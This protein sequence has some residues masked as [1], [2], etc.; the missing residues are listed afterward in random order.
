MPRTLNATL[1]AALDSG[2]FQAYF[3]LTVREVGAV[4][5]Y[6][7]ATPLKFELHGINLS[8]TYKR[9]QGSVYDGFLYP[10]EMEFMVTRGVTIAGVN[11]TINSSYYFGVTQVW[12]GKFQSIT[13]C[14]LPEQKY[15]AA[16]DVSYKTVIDAICAN[17]NK[18]AVY[19]TIGAAWQ[20]Y[21]FLGA[22]KIL[23]L[24]R[25]NGIL[26]MLKQ[27]YLIHA[28]DNG[29]N[30]I[31]FKAI[32]TDPAGSADHTLSLGIF[33]EWSG[34]VSTYRRFLY[35]D[36]AGTI[37]YSGN[38]T[39]PLWNLG[40]LES[41]AAA[42]T[43]KLSTAFTANPI[44]PHLKYLSFDRFNFTMEKYPPHPIT[45]LIG[46]NG[47]VTEEFDYKL[48]E[49]PWRITIESYNWA[50]GTEGGALPGTIEQAAPYTPLNVSNFANVLSSTD[51]N[52]QAA[53]E[54]LDDH[55]H[56]GAATT[57]G[58]QDIIGAMFSGN[59]ETGI[60]VTYQ[61]SDGTIDFEVTPAGVGAMPS[62]AI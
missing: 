24:N 62:L 38:A 55:D 61:D 5:P 33:K 34:D 15:T 50:K 36:E 8:A 21:K 6:E 40:Y 56:S 37:H 41:T 59:T 42:P 20:S 31:L 28:V 39:D 58:I 29:S 17:Y 45:D 43:Q 25:A 54:T 4:T 27:K 9:L 1:E 51:N 46:F 12:D 48:S 22:G 23:N 57:E 26:N 7:T 35:R 14:M 47:N 3:L 49:I 11:Y 10:H 16:G 44:A 2:S 52:I 53:M 18:T 60:T 13:A 19:D 30:Q 32:A